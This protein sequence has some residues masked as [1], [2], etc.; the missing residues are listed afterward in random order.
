MVQAFPKLEPMGKGRV[1]IYIY[2]STMA[3]KIK[4]LVLKLNQPEVLKHLKTRFDN[5]TNQSC[6]KN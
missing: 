4:E 6:K 1:Y 5:L 2:P 3:L